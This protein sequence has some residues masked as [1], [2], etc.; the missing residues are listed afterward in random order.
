MLKLAY[1]IF[2]ATTS[3]LLF[4]FSK[5]KKSTSVCAHEVTGSIN[6]IKDSTESYL[7][8]VTQDGRLLRPSSMNEEVVLAAG[9][10]VSVCY[11]IDSTKLSGHPSYLPVHIQAINY[12]P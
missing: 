12:R 11:N 4:I 1:V 9:Q 8:I 3:M 2:L 10:K 6:L 5:E 7:A